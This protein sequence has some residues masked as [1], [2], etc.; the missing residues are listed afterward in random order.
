MS[1]A[2]NMKMKEYFTNVIK[3]EETAPSD[4]S[5]NNFIRLNKSSS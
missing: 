4:L 5:G 2:K 3:H 1:E